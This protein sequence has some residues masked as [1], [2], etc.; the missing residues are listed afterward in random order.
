MSL[1]DPISDM[2]VRIKNAQAVTKKHVVFPA[3]KLKS[4]I[5]EVLKEE[6][7]IDSFETNHEIK[8]ETKVLL[9]YYDGS[10]VIEEI[11]RV[12]RP[13]LR[14]YK[15]ATELPLVKGGLGIAVVSTCQG[16]MT[17][18]NAQSKNLGGELLC[19]VA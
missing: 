7:Y 8:A 2:L 1:Q 3:S 19:V 16:V 4:S 14:I 9:K 18:R 5:L 6:G 15:G 10:P 11:R 13:G 12:S 17:A